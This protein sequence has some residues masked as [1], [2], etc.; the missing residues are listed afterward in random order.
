MGVSADE[1]SEQKLPELDTSG[2]VIVGWDPEDPQRWDS[3]VAWKTLI[4]STYS[5]FLGFCVWFMVSAIAPKLNEIG[6]DLS[7][8]QLSTGSPRCPACPEAFSA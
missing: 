7:S 3:K 1:S 2:R 6:F 8:A 5:L 4:V